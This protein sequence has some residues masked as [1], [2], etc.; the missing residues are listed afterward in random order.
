[1]GACLVLPGIEDASFAR[2][3]FLEANLESVKV[4]RRGGGAINGHC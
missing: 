1:M 2:H 3:F 4:P